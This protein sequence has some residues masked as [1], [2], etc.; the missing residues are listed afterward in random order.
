MNFFILATVHFDSAWRLRNCHAVL[1]GFFVEQT[2][3]RIY[4]YGT[5]LF[6]LVCLLGGALTSCGVVWN[7]LVFIWVIAVAV[8]ALL[9]AVLCVLAV[10]LRI[11]R[12]HSL[13]E[14]KRLV[15]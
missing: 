1:S 8:K 11:Y 15:H 9:T 12:G 13:A 5:E 2:A 14:I 6:V 10:G 4:V 3:L 7:V